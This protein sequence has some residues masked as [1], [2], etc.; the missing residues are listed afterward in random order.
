VQEAQQLQIHQLMQQMEAH[1]HALPAH[2][3]QQA[4]AVKG[5]TLS[6]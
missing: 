6:F 2:V 5:A 1:I 4:T 3:Q